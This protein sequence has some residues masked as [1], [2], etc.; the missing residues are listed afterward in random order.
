MSAT[1]RLKPAPG[2]KVRR[3][4]GQHLAEGGENVE[5]SP[6]WLR[7][8]A[9]GDVEEVKAVAMPAAVEINSAD[10]GRNNRKRG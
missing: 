2:L 3:P 1:K 9:H 5:L 7:R 8:L 4:D 6:Y 10:E